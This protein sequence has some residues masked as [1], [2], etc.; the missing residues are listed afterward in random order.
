MDTQDVR[1]AQLR[2]LLAEAQYVV[3]EHLR[4]SILGDPTTDAEHSAD[5]SGMALSVCLGTAALRLRT[6]QEA[7]VLP[8]S[9]LTRKS[10]QQQHHITSRRATLE[11]LLL[12]PDKGYRFAE[13]VAAGLMSKDISMDEA[14]SVSYRMINWWHKMLR[15]GAEPVI[16][17]VGIERVQTREYA[18]YGVNPYFNIESVTHVEGEVYLI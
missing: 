18:L 6:E 5:S 2:L 1:E 17:Q 15:I 8:Y 4:T 10:E 14:R 3:P 7:I 16:K 12:H 13:F 11:H 9:I